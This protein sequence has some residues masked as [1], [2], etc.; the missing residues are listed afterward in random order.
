[1]ISRTSRMVVT[2]PLFEALQCL[3]GVTPPAYV[4]G[5]FN[6]SELGDDVMALQD[7]CCNHARPAWSTGIAILDAADNIVSEAVGNANIAPRPGR[8]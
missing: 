3:T 5:L 1:M 8:R 4:R 6:S 7:W 2:D